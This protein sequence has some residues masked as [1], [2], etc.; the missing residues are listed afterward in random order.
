MKNNLRPALILFAVLTFLTGVVYPLL[1]TGVA[2]TLFP[3]QAHGSLLLRDGKPVGSALIGQNSSGVAP[4]LPAR[5][6]TT[7]VPP[8]APTRDR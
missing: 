8:V 2:Q 6:P 1:V 5:W 3:T 4:L 7:P